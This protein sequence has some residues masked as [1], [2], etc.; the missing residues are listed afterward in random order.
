MSN[1]V[2]FATTDRGQG[3]NGGQGKLFPDRFAVLEAQ[4]KDAVYML[5]VR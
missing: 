4:F 3:I 5:Q 2:S 1:P